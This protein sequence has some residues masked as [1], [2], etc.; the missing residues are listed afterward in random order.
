MAGPLR[1]MK[2]PSTVMAQCIT[3]NISWY[4][5]GMYNDEMCWRC[6]D[7]RNRLRQGLPLKTLRVRPLTF[8]QLRGAASQNGWDSFRMVEYIKVQ[9]LVEWAEGAREGPWWAYPDDGLRPGF[10]KPGPAEVDISKPILAS[11]LG[12]GT[13][14]A[15][16]EQ[17][18]KKRKS[19]VRRKRL[20]MSEWLREELRVLRGRT[21]LNIKDFGVMVGISSSS[22]YEYENGSR[23]TISQVLYGRWKK[24]AYSR[25]RR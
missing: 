11:R 18:L 9:E 17:W 1:R 21:G 22:V 3:C 8:D 20:N 15:G 2:A 23:R 19:P 25:E 16:T 12:G 10:C 13:I 24:V 5:T 6:F 4:A 14:S 7:R